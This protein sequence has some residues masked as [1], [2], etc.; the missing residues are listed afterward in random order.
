M[1]NV[2]TCSCAAASGEHL[3]CRTIFHPLIRPL[4][5]PTRDHLRLDL[6]GTFE[7]VDSLTGDAPP[8][9]QLGGIG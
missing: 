4:Q 8:A 9:A 5:Q 6:G 7:D 2:A 3:C 1:P